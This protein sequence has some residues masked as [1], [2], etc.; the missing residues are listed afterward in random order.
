[1]FMDPLLDI[2]DKSALLELPESKVRNSVASVWTAQFLSDRFPHHLVLR[3]GLAAQFYLEWPNQRLTSDIDFYADPHESDFESFGRLIKSTLLES[4]LLRG[5]ELRPSEAFE[6]SIPMFTF[7]LDFDHMR[8]PVSLDGVRIKLDITLAS[9]PLPDARIQGNLFQ[10]ALM[11]SVRVV[12]LELVLSEKLVKFASEGVSFPSRQPG[13]LC[14]QIYDLSNLL[15]SSLWSGDLSMLKPHF[16]FMRRRENAYR[17]RDL[18]YEELL[19]MIC[20]GFYTW[21]EYFVS[22]EGREKIEEFE[23]SS[24][25]SVNR[26]GLEAW[27]NRRLKVAKLIESL[28]A[29]K[30]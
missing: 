1:M 5:I 8:N 10:F 18:S 7:D 17:R 4:K 12:P 3:G 30:N 6:I 21:S 19:E 24:V 25:P 22:D 15:S 20:S 9:T 28:L 16:E 27:I 11:S 2:C 14:K 26:L 23:R 13:R 29:Q